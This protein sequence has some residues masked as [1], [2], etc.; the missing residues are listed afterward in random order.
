MLYLN[1]RM[2]GLPL[3]WLVPDG[4]H[5]SGRNETW[6]HP[7][8]DR[9]ISGRHPGIMIRQGGPVGEDFEITRGLF[10]NGERVA[11]AAVRFERSSAPG[12]AMV[13]IPD[14]LSCTTDNGTLLPERAPRIACRKDG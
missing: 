3:L 9:S 4:D 14:G 13:S 1:A 8:D 12:G 5:V 11:E 10:V 2:A 7:A 6:G